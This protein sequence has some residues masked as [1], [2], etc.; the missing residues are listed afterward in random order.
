MPVFGVT[1]PSFQNFTSFQERDVV[2]MTSEATS[3]KCQ[4]AP[5]W[6]N[7]VDVTVETP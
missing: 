4:E 2:V 5:H 1:P 7:I 3:N 6:G